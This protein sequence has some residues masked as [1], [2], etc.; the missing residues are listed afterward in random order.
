M[1]F[2]II[3][4]KNI[5][6]SEKASSCIFYLFFYFIILYYILLYFRALLYFKSCYNVQ[7]IYVEYLESIIFLFY[8]P[9]F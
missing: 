8:L 5:I 4:F 7:C 2:K 3:L 1:T 9:V 6:S